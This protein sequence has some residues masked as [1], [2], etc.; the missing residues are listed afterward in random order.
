MREKIFVGKM[1]DMRRCVCK[2][3]GEGI[4]KKVYVIEMGGER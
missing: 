2:R 4:R 3:N 1:G